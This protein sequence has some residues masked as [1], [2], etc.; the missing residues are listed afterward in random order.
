MRTQNSETNLSLIE[1][2]LYTAVLKVLA[3]KVLESCVRTVCGHHPL[4]VSATAPSDSR[5]T[6]LPSL[7]LGRGLYSSL[8]IKGLSD[9]QRSC[10]SPKTSHLRRQ[11][12]EA[13]TSGPLRWGVTSS[14][15]YTRVRGASHVAFSQ[16]PRDNSANRLPAAGE[17]LVSSPDATAQ[18]AG[19][20]CLKRTCRPY[21]MRAV[22]IV[23]GFFRPHRPQ[24]T[25]CRALRGR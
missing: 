15:P 17:L 21:H 14:A 12:T 4:E 7:R 19:E 24:L 18:P 22:Q 16:F 8:K 20:S 2:S 10:L 13:A 23:S 6:S 11:P 9:A 25:D 5:T 3:R 1:H